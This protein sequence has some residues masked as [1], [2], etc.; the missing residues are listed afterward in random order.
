M[1]GLVVAAV[2]PGRSWHT[3][4]S[5]HPYTLAGRE[6]YVDGVEIGECG[7]AHPDLLPAGSTG[8]A[9]GLGLDRLTMLAKGIPDIRLLRSTDP[10]VAEQMLDLTRYWPVST[11]PV[12]TRDLSLAVANELDTELLG[13]R[14]RQILGRDAD[15]VEEVSI[16][17]ETPV[18]DAAR[19]SPRP[20]GHARR[21]EERAATGRAPQPGP[22]HDDSASQSSAR[23][24]VRS[25][26][27]EGACTS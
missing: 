25:H 8:L 21:A 4:R 16:R 17:S 6:I 27:H 20:D 7:L 15:L 13:D 22:H 5:E 10:R 26:L 1:V 12:V 19:L 2:L 24:A 11:M 14:V 3:P 9:M 23:S 18:R